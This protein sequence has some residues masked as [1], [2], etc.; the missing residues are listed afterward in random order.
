[1]GLQ[2]ESAGS[3]KACERVLNDCRG[4]RGGIVR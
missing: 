2:R 4:N 3:G 1:M